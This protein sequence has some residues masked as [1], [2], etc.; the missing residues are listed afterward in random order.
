MIGYSEAKRIAS[1]YVAAIP[2][3]NDL[4]TFV[5][6]ESQTI[7]R[8]IGWVFFYTSVKNPELVLGNSPFLIRRE[9]GAMHK[10]GTALPAEEALQKLAKEMTADEYKLRGS[11]Q[12]GN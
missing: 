1:E 3:H 6:L 10:L 7:E 5:L 2:A 4:G 8:P 12:G 11:S 9:N